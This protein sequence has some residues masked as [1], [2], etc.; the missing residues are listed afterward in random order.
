MSNWSLV[1]LIL[2]V[3]SNTKTFVMSQRRITDD[4]VL[5]LDPILLK[6]GQDGREEG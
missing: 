2:S 1:I 3:T 4:G 5:L 6:G